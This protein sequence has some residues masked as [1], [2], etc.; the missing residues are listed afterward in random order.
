VAKKEEKGKSLQSWRV[1]SSA[2]TRVAAV[3]MAAELL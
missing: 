2:V 3:T 1:W